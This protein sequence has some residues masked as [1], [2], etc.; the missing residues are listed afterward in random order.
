MSRVFYT[1]LPPHLRFTLLALADHADDDGTG[2]YVGQ[3]RL[4]RKVGIRVRAVHANLCALRDQGYLVQEP[5]SGRN[6]VHCYRIDVTK[7][8][9]AEA[10]KAPVDR[11]ST[12]PPPE[13]IDRQ[14]TADRQSTTDR[15][16][17]V[18]STGSPAS[19]DRQPTADKPKATKKQP[20]DSPA[21]EERQEVEAFVTLYHRLCPMLPRCLELTAK[22]RQHIAARLRERPLPEW[23]RVFG[24]LAA[25]RFHTGENDR[26]WRADIDW[27]SRSP[28]SAVKLL[29]RGDVA[30]VRPVAYAA[31][32]VRMRTV[33]ETRAR[34]AAI[35]GGR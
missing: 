19:I 10:C 5:R 22:R 1:D 33:E 14:S 16:S 9:S 23:E 4:A 18:P 2:I 26:G 20:T 30:P 3:E 13:S 12:T 11:Q 28:D 25:S 6:G 17:T 24:L 21:R 15:Q 29:E 34:L 35:Q 32:G 8:P 31:G 27:I 7:L